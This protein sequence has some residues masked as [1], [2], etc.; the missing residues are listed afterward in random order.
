MACSTLFLDE[1][2]TGTHL[3]GDTPKQWGP[4]DG[5]TESFV[6]VF[7]FDS[8]TGISIDIWATI[9]PP[10]DAATENK[11]SE[12]YITI[13]IVLYFITLFFEVLLMLFIM[14]AQGTECMLL[15]MQVTMVLFQPPANDGKPVLAVT[16]VNSLPSCRPPMNVAGFYQIDSQLQ[17]VSI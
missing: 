9:Q 1:M 6:C 14:F 16:T 8:S 5:L 12:T 17:P 2:P 10:S 15:A 7:Y 11:Q 4:V 3:L 13:T